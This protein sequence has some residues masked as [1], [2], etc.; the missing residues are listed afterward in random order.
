ME[1]L[2]INLR[3]VLATLLEKHR[4]V[5]GDA[6]ALN[7]AQSAFESYRDYQCVAENKRI[8]DK[9]YHPMIIAQCKTRL[10]NLRLDEL[11]RMQNQDL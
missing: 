5:F 6:N 9:P 11:T 2:E 8:E 1:K 3:K 7:N 4:A 10:T